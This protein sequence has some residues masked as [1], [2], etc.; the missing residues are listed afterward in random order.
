[1]P[2]RATTRKDPLSQEERMVKANKPT[3][4]GLT[5]CMPSKTT[6]LADSTNIIVFVATIST[7]SLQH[8]MP[9][10]SEWTTQQSLGINQPSEQ[11]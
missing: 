11:E 7:I 3:T 9:I 10:L 6:N 8:Y 2:E 5:E 1:M 4:T